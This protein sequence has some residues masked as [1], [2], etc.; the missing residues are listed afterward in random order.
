MGPVPVCFVSTLCPSGTM[1]FFFPVYKDK[2]FQ[3]VINTILNL[4]S[5]I[6]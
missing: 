2:S 3:V 4:D 6:Y 1:N 5:N